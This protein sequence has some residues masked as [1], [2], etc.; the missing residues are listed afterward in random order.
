MLHP[1][2][3]LPDFSLVGLIGIGLCSGSGVHPQSGMGE[4]G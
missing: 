2:I 1:N 4:G 3:P